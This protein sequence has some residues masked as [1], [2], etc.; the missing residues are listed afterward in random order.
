MKRFL[1]RSTLLTL[2]FFFIGLILYT[3]V[4][5]Q[6]YQHIYPV[7]LIFFFLATNLVHAYL[8]RIAGKDMAKFT[9]RYM[10]LSF[11]KMLFYL[12]IAIVFIYI[13]KDQTKSFLINYLSVYVG[14][15]VLEVAEISRVVKINS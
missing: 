6:Y 3:Q 4:I 9:T 8:L 5:P 7:A 10:A 14:F 13:N 11:L 15:T 12:I 1:V 2:L